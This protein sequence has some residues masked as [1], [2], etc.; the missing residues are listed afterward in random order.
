M[1][2]DFEQERVDLR[3]ETISDIENALDNMWTAEQFDVYKEYC[4]E[5]GCYD[6]EPFSIDEIDEFCYGLTPTDILAKFE[7]IDMSWDY[8]CFDGYG[9][10]EEWE[11]IGYTYEVAEW[12]VDNENSCCNS[13]IEAILDDYLEKLEEIDNAEDEYDEEDE[14]E[15]DDE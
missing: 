14:T 13:E 9:N 12:I 4:C 2:R 3:E 5:Y 7:G 10:V 1:A 8:F 11:G 15:E 6:D